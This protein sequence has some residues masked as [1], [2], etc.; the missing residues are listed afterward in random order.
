[1]DW[2]AE[3]I[4]SSALEFV[5]YSL[6]FFNDGHRA[7]SDC[8][9]TLHMLAQRLPGHRAA[10]IAGSFGTGEL[11]S[12]RLWARDAAVF[13][14]KSDRALSPS[15]QPHDNMPL[16]LRGRQWRASI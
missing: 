16:A 7:A 1:M 8:R 4:R 2:K 6:R 13:G 12:W 3:G 11:P 15:P 5:A 14:H 9:A 10:G